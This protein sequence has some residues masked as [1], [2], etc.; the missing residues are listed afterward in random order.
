MT[1]DVNQSPRRPHLG[2]ASARA[3]WELKPLVDTANTF[4]SVS[5]RGLGSQWSPA[6]GAGDDRFAQD[7]MP[8]LEE[9]DEE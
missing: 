3:C 5:S 8:E 4:R 2:R 6:E 7:A 1:L 9:L